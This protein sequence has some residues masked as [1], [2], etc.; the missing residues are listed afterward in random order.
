MGGSRGQRWACDRAREAVSLRLDGELSQLGRAFLDR[1][2]ERCA[3]CAQ[4]ADDVSAFTEELRDAAGVPLDR[5]IALPART[6]TG[7]AFRHVGAWVAA[8]S[9]AATA[10]L[11]VFSLP[12]QRP[13]G[14]PAGYGTDAGTSS[15]VRPNQ[16][17]RDLRYLRIRQM[18]PPALKLAQLAHG[19]QLNS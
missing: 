15:T 8:A 14:R 2:L 6:R 16:D 4:F 11:A 3:S 17:L 9:V 5:P 1:H 13:N 10:L 7:Y 18:K 19:Q 12:A